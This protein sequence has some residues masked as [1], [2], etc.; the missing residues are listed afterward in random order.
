MN[1]ASEKL[2]QREMEKAR[3]RL[4]AYV[5]GDISLLLNEETYRLSTELDRLIVNLMKKSQRNKMQK[6]QL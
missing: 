3:R 5:N 1:S 6:T 4:H 2:L